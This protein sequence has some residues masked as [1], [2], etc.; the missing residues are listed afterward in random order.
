[1]IVSSPHH[2]LLQLLRC[3]YR[4][5][6]ARFSKP[7][8]Q[9]TSTRRPSKAPKPTI[10]I[11]KIQQNP[12]LHSQ[13][14]LHRN[15]KDQ[16]RNP[17][18]IVELVDQRQKLQR[19]NVGLR[20]N[21]KKL[22]AE[23]D[24]CRGPRE[25]HIRKDSDAANSSTGN[26]LQ[27]ARRLKQE[28]RTLEAKEDAL[29]TEIEDLASGLPNLTSFETPLGSKPNIIGYINDLL[30]FAQLSSFRDHVSI[31]TELDLLDFTAASTTSGWGWYYLKKGA[32][33]L[34]QALVQYAVQT[35]IRQ[36]FIP[37]SP[38]SVI[39]SH[40]ASAAGFRPRD[41][42]GEQQVYAL[43]QAKK[44][45]TKPELSLAGTAEI[46]FAAMK[47]GM[48]IEVSELPLQIVGA[49]R[50]YRAEAGARGVDTKGLYRVHEFTKVEMFGWTRSTDE[51]A[52]ALFTTML[53]VQ[54]EILRSL[55]LSCRILEMPSHDLGASAFRKQDIEVFFPSRAKRSGGWGEVTSTSI[56]TD[57]Q[58]RRLGTRVRDEEGKA[59]FPYTVNGTALAVPRVLAALLEVGWMEEEK[60]VKVPEVL[61][62]WMGGVKILQKE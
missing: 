54:T 9:S 23:L 18:K 2:C 38:P 25:D 5:S 19:E 7:A 26:N 59:V 14:C 62:P 47:A 27:Y 48:D 60:C 34:E 51:A 50:C 46:P 4:E 20:Q 32:A 55:G 41:Q 45:K 61:W 29:N 49:S 21:H 1:M 40:I 28:M 53:N 37:V 58:T 24:K 10:D 16:Q 35:A 8:V 17:F 43:Q 15:Y 30:P 13:N 33:L 11:K 44:D 12:L 56:C 42:N 39:Y 3:T 52:T 57:Y 6:R 31:G 36:A 22:Q